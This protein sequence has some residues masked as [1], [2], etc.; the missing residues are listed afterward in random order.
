M[1][2]IITDVNGYLRML[3]QILKD[4]KH[5]KNFLCETEETENRDQKIVYL[6]GNTSC[7][8]DSFITSLLL[9]IFKNFLKDDN[10]LNKENFKNSPKIFI[11]IFNCKREDF[12]DRL[13]LFYLLKHYHINT[14]YLFFINDEIISDELFLFEII[15]LDFDRNNL[16]EN[17]KI[18]I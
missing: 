13:D 8:M 16:I 15:S 3:Y 9:S 11:P 5:E 2:N 1:D 6:L 14:E 7:D 18:I 10:N 17:S 12:C 4:L